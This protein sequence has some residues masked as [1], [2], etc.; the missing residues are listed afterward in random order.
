MSTTS[1]SSP[2]RRAPGAK[3]L[4]AR[5]LAEFTVIVVGV[6]VAL[7]ADRWNQARSDALLEAAYLDR[8]VFDIRGDSLRAA[9]AIDEIPSAYA[10]RDSLIAAVEGR[11]ALPVDMVEAIE[12]AWHTLAFTSPPTWE[13]LKATGNLVLIRDPRARQALSDYYSRREGALRNLSSAELRGRYP[14]VDVI[15]QLGLV[16]IPPYPGAKEEFLAWPDMRR[17]LVGL[18]G[19][20]DIMEFFALQLTEEAGTVLRALGDVRDRSR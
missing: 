15:Y 4:A 17:R 8:L 9:A 2:T 3:A 1:E 11:G 12:H 10:A 6:L 13:E 20:Y 16:E 19:H 7:A 18:G 14:F 5:W